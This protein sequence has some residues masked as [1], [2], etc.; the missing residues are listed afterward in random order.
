MGVDEGY[1][2]HCSHPPTL[3]RLSIYGRK[4]G[5][6]MALSGFLLAA[7]TRNTLQQALAPHKMR[8]VGVDVPVS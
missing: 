1:A 8:I 3:S 6:I 2:G 4:G 7:A 5:A